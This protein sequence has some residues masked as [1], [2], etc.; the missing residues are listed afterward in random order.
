MKLKKSVKAYRKGYQR[1]ANELSRQRS[2]LCPLV[3]VVNSRELVA[4][5]TYHQ[6]KRLQK[7]NSHH[8]PK[9]KERKEKKG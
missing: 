7:T 8:W 4:N 5:G 1:Q 6:S 3:E 9:R 2:I